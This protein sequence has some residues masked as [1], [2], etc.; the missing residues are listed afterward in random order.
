MVDPLARALGQQPSVLALF[1]SAVLLRGGRQ[2]PEKLILLQTPSLSLLE[3]VSAI[4]EG[5][6]ASFVST[7]APPLCKL[8]LDSRCFK[9]LRWRGRF[10]SREWN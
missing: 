6:E 3:R 8:P 4:T 10:P 7:N 1:V 2:N 9:S 5:S